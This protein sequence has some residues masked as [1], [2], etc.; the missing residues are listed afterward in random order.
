MD[1]RIL[2]PLEVENNGRAVELGGA[3]QRALLAILLLHR[4]E[5]VSADRLIED[6]YRGEPP[7]TAAKSL[8]AH[9]S[10]LRRALT[11]AKRLHTRAGGYVLEV[12]A[13]EVD[14]DRLAQ[15]LGEGRRALSADEPLVASESLDAALRLWRGSPLV[16]VAYETFAWDE[17]A[18]LEE[19]RLQC[20][21]E[22]L[23][24]DLKL[25]RHAAVVGE[26]ERLV[27]DHPA[28]E[29][30]RAQ[31]M[32]ALYRCGRQAE[33]LEE[34][35][36]ARGALVEE[37]GIEP[38]RPLREL[39]QAILRQDPALD[40]APLPEP[41]PEPARSAFVGREAELGELVSS[42]A[43]RARSRTRSG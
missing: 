21:E 40:L 37:L 30:L 9:V 13:D 14:A 7:A 8:Q 33:A 2:G 25:G 5:V 11:P 22:R 34:Y 4:R 18:R 23:E 1:F 39:H 43:G 28:R 3:R 31:L 6:L 12:G 41:A 24:A 36:V 38:G 27:T 26:L 29:R 42:W 35:Q 15:L 10:R 19:L 20:F 17:I 16:D 32:V